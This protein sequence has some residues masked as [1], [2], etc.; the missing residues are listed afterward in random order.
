MTRYAF[1]RSR[2]WVGIIALAL[3][4]AVACAL[5]GRWQFHRYEGKARMLELVEANYSA[6]AVPLADEL[7]RS[8]D[9]ALEWRPVEVTGRFVGDPVVLPQRGVLGS[10]G[11]HLLGVFEVSATGAYVV[12]DR[13]WLPIDEV[14]GP[15]EASE[16]A[17]SREHTPPRGDVTVTGRLRPAEVAS[18]RGIRDR[19]VFVI[20]P[21]QVLEAAGLTAQEQVLAQA[22]YL[23]GMPGPAQA[24]LQEFPRP[25]EDLGPHLS[26]AFQWWVFSLGALVGLGVLARRESVIDSGEAPPPR[27]RARDADEEDA[28][29]DAQLD[30]AERD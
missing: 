20:N 26:Y 25:E 28:L 23:Q 6:P 10:A 4:V 18:E 29:I 13:G 22:G 14:G 7:T 15:D 27:R 12:V 11:D 19:Q 3:I 9:P 1:L 21:A 8:F 24:G 2:R 17:G 30:E 5:L 16:A